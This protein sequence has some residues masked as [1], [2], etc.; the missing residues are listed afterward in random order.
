MVNNWVFVHYNSRN[1]KLVIT[2]SVFI[3]IVE[4]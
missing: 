2:G 1:V 4:M 3:P